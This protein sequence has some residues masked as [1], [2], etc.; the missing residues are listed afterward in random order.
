MKHSRICLNFS[1]GLLFN[2][3]SNFSIA[4]NGYEDDGFLGAFCCPAMCDKS[5]L[6]AHEAA[7]AL[8]QMQDAGAIPALMATLQDTQSFHPIVRHEVRA[9]TSF[10]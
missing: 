9:H 7:F 2:F 10:L 5:N 8:G 1:N 3:A 4:S 6:L